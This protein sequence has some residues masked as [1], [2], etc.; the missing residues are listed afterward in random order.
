MMLQNH[1]WVKESIQSE[2]PMDSDVPSQEEFIDMISESTWQLT[3]RKLPL[4]EL[5]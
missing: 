1:T 2:R 3:F 5:C 4:V